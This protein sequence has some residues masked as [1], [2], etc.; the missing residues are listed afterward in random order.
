MKKIRK[1]LLGIL[2]I[3][4]VIGITGVFF[5]T[6]GLEEGKELTV[7]S[8]DIGSLED[9]IYLGEYDYKRWANQVEVRVEN[10]EILDIQLI[11]G[12]KH[13]EAMEKIYDSVIKSQ[14]LEVDT[15]SGATVSSKAYLKAIE[16][17]LKGSPVD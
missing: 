16:E 11:D 7:E 2:L 15:V 4:A 1:V 6:R 10:G 3:F 17:A 14:S 13:Q 12:F 5:A 9:G 8:I